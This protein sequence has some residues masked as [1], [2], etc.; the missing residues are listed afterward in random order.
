[1]F[2]RL[3]KKWGVG[4]GRL[5]LILCTFA[6]GG[7]LCGWAGRKLM[8]LSGLEKG[9]GWWVLYLLLITLLWPMAVLL[10]SILTGQFRFFKNYLRK[11]A[12]RM[13]F[14]RRDVTAKDLPADKKSV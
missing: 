4:P 11:V 9:V 13:G 14:G 12:R 3:Q 2:N 1:M 8:E 7:S 5:A 6:I 10:V